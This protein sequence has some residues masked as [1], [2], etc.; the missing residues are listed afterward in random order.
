MEQQSLFSQLFLN[1]LKNVFTGVVKAE[2]TSHQQPVTVNDQSQTFLTRKETAALLGVS[3]PTLHHW[4]VEGK[5]PAYRIGTRVRYKRAE[6][7]QSLHLIRTVK[8]AGGAKW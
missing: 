4:T 5:V 3:L 1:E 6:V 8:T 2:I 7:E